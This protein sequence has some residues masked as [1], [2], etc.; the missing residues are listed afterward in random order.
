MHSNE[1]HS[2]YRAFIEIHA[3]QEAI[4]FLLDGMSSSFNIY[5]L[6]NCS[7]AVYLKAYTAITLFIKALTGD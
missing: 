2:L 5:T 7:K 4:I 1:L 6:F 3:K